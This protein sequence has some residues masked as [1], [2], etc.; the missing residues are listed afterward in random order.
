ML[1]WAEVADPVVGPG[2]VLIDVAASAVN[3]ADLLQAAGMYPPPPGASEILG[4]ECSG[5]VAGVG[6]DV[7]G[8]QVGDQV[9]ALLAGGGYAERVAV[10]AAQVLP[11]PEGGRSRHRG[12]FARGVLH[13]VVEP[14]DDRGPARA[15][16]RAH[17]RRWLRDRDDGHPGRH[18][19]GATVAVTG[20]RPRHCRPAWTSAPSSRSTTSSRTSSRR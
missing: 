7:I 18:A 8:W 1:R 16:D 2:E 4:M 3:R 10:P 6:P 13:G 14:G 19:G 12:R 5:V 17:P 15:A 9:C 20:S 11:G